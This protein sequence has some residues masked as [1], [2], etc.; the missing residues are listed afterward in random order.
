M[1]KL[2]VYAQALRGVGEIV[3]Y[4][5]A[6]KHHARVP[7]NVTTQFA[8][9]RQAANVRA[10]IETP[11]GLINIALLGW[12]PSRTGEVPGYNGEAVVSEKT[13]AG[14]IIQKYRES[15]MV[16]NM[17]ESCA[18]LTYCLEQM[19]TGSL[20]SGENAIKAKAAAELARIGKLKVK[21]LVIEKKEGQPV[22]FNQT[23]VRALM[24]A[25]ITAWREFE[26]LEPKAKGRKSTKQTI[27]F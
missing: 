25:G 5:L 17:R 7:N 20:I 13:A 23:Q 26:D 27:Q 4:A 21:S 22:T 6:R 18:L 3:D 12:Q 1:A 19:V 15:S 10:E 8:A 14:Q 9:N 16:D 2:T 24:T 11:D